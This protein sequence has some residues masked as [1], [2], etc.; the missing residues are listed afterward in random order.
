MKI[1]PGIFGAVQGSE[2]KKE[3]V[4]ASQEESSVPQDGVSLSQDGSFIQ[5]LR[6]AAEGKEPLRSEL[7]ERAKEDLASGLLGSKEDY[8]QAI[9]AL[10][11]E[12]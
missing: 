5:L 2:S 4:S 3:R 10:L 12:L 8:E 7:V 6:Q 9:N 11:S 1:K